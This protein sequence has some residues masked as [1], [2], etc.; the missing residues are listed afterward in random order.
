MRAKWWST[1]WTF[2][3]I[4]KRCRCH[5]ECCW[6][7][8]VSVNIRGDI[9]FTIMIVD[10]LLNV[11]F[12][13]LGVETLGLGWSCGRLCVWCS[14]QH[15]WWHN[16]CYYDYV[17]NVLFVSARCDTVVLGGSGGQPC[18]HS[19]DY[20]SDMLPSHGVLLTVWWSC[21][22]SRWHNYYYCDCVLNVLFISAMRW[23][24]SM[25]AKCSSSTSTICRVHERCRSHMECCWLFGLPVNILGDIVLRRLFAEC[26]VC[27]S[28]VLTLLD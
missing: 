2:C 5:M 16:Y 8:A 24:C 6:L 23:H 21:Q 15:S 3:R 26:S 27:F 9:V 28:M 19:K 10:C 12:L 7:F 18:R 4:H 11:L 1:L 22:H 13:Q 17:L 14:C 20:T 25:R